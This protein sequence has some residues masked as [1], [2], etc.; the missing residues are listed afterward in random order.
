M[1][2]EKE[3]TECN[4]GE[5]KNVLANVI[6]HQTPVE[7]MESVVALSQSSG[8]NRNEMLA[9]MTRSHR[10]VKVDPMSSPSNSVG[11]ISPNNVGIVIPTENAKSFWAFKNYTTPTPQRSRSRLPLI[12]MHEEDKMS[13]YSIEKEDWIVDND[14]YFE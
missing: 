5:W 10:N 7:E 6:V 13:A 4:L 8:I 3:E 12:A 14:E 11:I 9:F 2:S 1:P